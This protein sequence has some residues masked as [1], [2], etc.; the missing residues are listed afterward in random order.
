MG[1][2]SL[3]IDSNV[4]IRFTS[5]SFP[6][7]CCKPSSTVPPSKCLNT[8]FALSASS[9]KST[10]VVLARVSL[11]TNTRLRVDTARLRASPFTVTTTCKNGLP[12]TIAADNEPSANEITSGIL[13]TSPTFNASGFTPIRLSSW[14]TVCALIP[15]FAA[16]LRLISFTL[17]SFIVVII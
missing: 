14:F 6:L 3:V 15:K 17:L 13:I 8:A 1:A 9:N 5:N 12:L 16:A 2:P 7:S 10:G 11:S 4:S